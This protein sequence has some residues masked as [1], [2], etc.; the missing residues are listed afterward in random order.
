MHSNGSQQPCPYIHKIEVS[1]CLIKKIKTK[2]AFENG[3]IS[4][5]AQCTCS[6]NKLVIRPKVAKQ[7]HTDTLSNGWPNTNTQKVDKFIPMPSMSEKQAW[8]KI[9]HFRS[10]RIM[11]FANLKG[12]KINYSYNMGNLL[13]WL[14]MSKL[15]TNKILFISWF[16]KETK[17]GRQETVT[18]FPHPTTAPQPTPFN[19]TLDTKAQHP[20]YVLNKIIFN[21]ARSLVLA[22]TYDSE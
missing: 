22:E 2:S 21:T 16:L 14:G 17:I 18:T 7:F 8:R 11:F 10:Y 9:L 5:K 20:A 19:D 12:N 3:S 1:N 13:E 4:Q 15:S 6:S